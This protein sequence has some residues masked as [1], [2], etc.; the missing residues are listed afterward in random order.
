MKFA[1]IQTITTAGHRGRMEDNKG[2][3][4]EPTAIGL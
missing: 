4:S 2:A 3:D 1:N